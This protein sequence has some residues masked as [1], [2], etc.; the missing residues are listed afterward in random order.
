MGSLQAQRAR[1]GHEVKQFAKRTK[2]MNEGRG[3]VGVAPM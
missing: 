1:D 2:R 3:R